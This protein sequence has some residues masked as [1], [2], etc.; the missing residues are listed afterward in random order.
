MSRRG[1]T[2]LLVMFVLAA[3]TA[4]G[5]VFASR[6]SVNQNARR[7]EAVRLQAL[8]LG[9]SACEARLTAPRRVRTEVGEAALSRSGTAVTVELSGGMATVDCTSHEERFAAH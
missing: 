8:W 7:A 9:R 4:A 5:V 6:L 3:V 2:V 1:Y